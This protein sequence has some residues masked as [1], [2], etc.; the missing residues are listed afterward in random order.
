MGRASFDRVI[1]AFTNQGLRVYQKGNDSA[2]AQAPGHSGRDRSV[3]IQSIEGSTLVYSFSDPI[4]DVLAALNL[5]MQDLFDE[6]RKGMDYRYQGGRVVHRSPDKRFFQSGNKEDRSLYRIE[7]VNGDV[8][9]VYVAEGEKDVLALEK[10]GLVAVCNPGGAGK[11]GLYDLEPLHGKTVRVVRDMDEPGLR[12]ALQVRDLLAGKAASV[13]LLQPHVGKDPAEHIAA[14]FGW[15]DFEPMVLPEE[16]AAPAPVDENFERLVA[17]KIEMLEVN[18]EVQRRRASVGAAILEPKYLADILNIADTQDWLIPG[19]LER[20]DRLILT[21]G[22]GSGKSYFSRQLAI[23]A[24]A[25]V[26]PFHNQQTAPIRVLAI[27]AENS[28]VQWARNARYVTNM[29]RQY[30]TDDPGKQVLVSAGTRLDLTRQADLD[31]VHKLM[32]S[33]KPDLVYIGP[34]YKL[35]AKA[36]NSDDDAA[37]LIV[38]L[39]GLRERGVALVMEAHAGHGKSLGGERDLRP[40]GSSALLGWPEFGLGLRPIEDDDSMVAVVRWRGDRDERHWPKH[41]RRGS[42]GEMPWMPA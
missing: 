23:A 1:D 10:L 26:H 35:L 20:R 16:Q 18:D 3:S 41:L 42:P 12:H 7:R 32:D 24:A 37:P 21:G 36:I 31:Q 38:A 40:R 9:V 8:S 33:H 13:E 25:G 29:A 28:E 15:G 14:G 4:T 6:P 19:L 5:T 22:E 11:F 17:Q 27:D 30:G 39:D 2:E 34:L